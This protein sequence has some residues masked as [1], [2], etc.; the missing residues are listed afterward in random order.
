MAAT[1]RPW[2]GIILAGGASRR[3]G[4]DKATLEWRGRR[5][6]DQIA[7]LITDLG[8][9]AVVVAGRD[10]GWPFVL[11]PYPQ[12][13][14]SVGIAL[15][16]RYL[17][18]QGCSRMIVLA[19]DAPTVTAADLQPLLEAENGAAYGGFPLPFTARIDALPTDVA[20]DTPLRRLIARM[21]LVELASSDDLARRLRGANTPDE[22]AAL[23]ADEAA[24]KDVASGPQT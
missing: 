14:P 22:R 17:R 21:G 3:M 1:M 19:V 20:P 12:A 4:A 16:A 24:P 10:Y 2:G 5:A 6:V 15:G 9:G 7:D 23:L 8:A 13:G 18:G 11:D